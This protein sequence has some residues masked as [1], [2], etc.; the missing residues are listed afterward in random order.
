MPTGASI[1]LS[2][3]AVLV[4]MAVA[5]AAS[6]ADPASSPDNVLDEVVVTAQRHSQDVQDIGVAIDTASGKQLE[7]L[8]IQQPLNFSM[9]ASGLSTMNS[10]TDSTP[11]FLI[12]GVGL[13]DFNTNNSSGVG[14]YLDEVFASLPGFL[15]E[16]MY[17]IDRVEILKGPQGTLYGKNTAG[18]AINILSA[19]PTDH[20]EGYADASYSRWETSDLTGA[21]SGPLNDFIKARLAATATLQGDGY[22]TDIDTGKKYGKLDRGGARSI[23]DVSGGSCCCQRQRG[24]PEGSNSGSVPAGA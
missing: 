23:F 19:Q 20:F 15:T 5:A 2:L 7:A 8:R 16:T 17:D 6:A 24:L 9:I 4:S 10:T 21:I 22:Q 11:L 12:R 13:D 14:T 18:G 3:A 1:H